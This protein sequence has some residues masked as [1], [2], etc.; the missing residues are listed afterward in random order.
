LETVLCEVE[1]VCNSR[2]LT[3]VSVVP[4]TPSMFL[5]DLKIAGVPD[6]ERIDEK[7][8]DRRVKYRQQ[9]RRDLRERFCFEYLGKL[10]HQ[11]HLKKCSIGVGEVVLIGEDNKK[12]LDWKLG[13]V[14]ELF[15]GRDG[16]SRV[17]KLKAAYGQV[18]RPA[19]RLYPLEMAKEDPVA[20]KMLQEEEKE[21][22]LGGEAAKTRNGR[23][24]KSPER[25]M[26]YCLTFSKV[27]GQRWEK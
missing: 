17:A 13:R 7:S 8:L 3:C 22:R 21:K 2:P 6:L 19:Q 10:I 25:F 11:H 1:E 23:R 24:I 14:L 18:T 26:D 5:M 27:E 15:P 20:E 16:I 4:L 9:L 12:R